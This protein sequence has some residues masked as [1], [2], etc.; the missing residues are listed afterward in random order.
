MDANS[1]QLKENR[2]SVW[3]RGNNFKNLCSPTE[4]GLVVK[5]NKRYVWRKTLD[6]IGEWEKTGELEYLRKDA[7]NGSL[8]WIHPKLIR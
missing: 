6:P 1:F 5:V 4:N 7:S 8:E 3:V 2:E